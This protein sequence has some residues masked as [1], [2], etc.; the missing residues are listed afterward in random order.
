MGAERSFGGDALRK[1][2]IKEIKKKSEQI[3]QAFLVPTYCSIY[4]AFT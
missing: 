3:K 2:L 4:I 1:T